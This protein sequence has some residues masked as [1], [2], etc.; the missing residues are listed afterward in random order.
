MSEHPLR[1]QPILF[2]TQMNTCHFA[3]CWWSTLADALKQLAVAGLIYNEVSALSGVYILPFSSFF[4]PF[5][6]HM[7]LQFITTVNLA[8]CIDDNACDKAFT[9]IQHC[10]SCLIWNSPVQSVLTYSSMIYRKTVASIQGFLFR[11]SLYSM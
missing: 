7:M 11:T 2:L 6:F 9:L 1:R 4:F 5:L 3:V 8:I 10:T